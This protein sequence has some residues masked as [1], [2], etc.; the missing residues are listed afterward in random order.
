MNNCPDA[1]E[2][3]AIARETLLARLLPALPEASRYDALMIANA[4]AIAARELAA[5]DV[6]AQS[7]LARL[8]ALYAESGK[9]V[10]GNTLHIALKDYNRRLTADIR[11]G[12]FDDR[13]RTALLDHLEKTAVD[14]LAVANPKALKS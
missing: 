11:G 1:A 4:M 3:L 10:S 7:E 9:D 14:K 13:E 5:G 2:L 12:R 6:A 8:N